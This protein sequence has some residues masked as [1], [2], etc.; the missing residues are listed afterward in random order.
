MNTA[1]PPSPG[2]D[3]LDT[4]SPDEA[5]HADALHRVYL[6]GLASGHMTAVHSI[7]GAPI[8][9]LAHTV[10]Q[11]TRAMRNDPLIRSAQVEIALANYRGDNEFP[12]WVKAMNSG[13]VLH[14]PGCTCGHHDDTDSGS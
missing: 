9:V 6:A 8:P 11:I 12:D 5:R 4:V 10:D 7:T 13:V 1:P 2:D 3:N 14:M